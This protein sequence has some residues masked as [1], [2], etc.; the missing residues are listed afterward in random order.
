M[1][2]RMAEEN[3]G[4]SGR[5]SMRGQWTAIFY[6]FEVIAFCFWI[7]VISLESAFW[8][9]QYDLFKAEW[10]IIAFSTFAIAI[11]V[12]QMMER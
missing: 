2:I 8:G 6:T 4:E 3:F 5:V 10:L 12:D 11:G 9:I 7:L 1:T